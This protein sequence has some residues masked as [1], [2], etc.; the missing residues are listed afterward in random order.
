MLGS[1]TYS[2][3]QVE[4]HRIDSKVVN[5]LGWNLQKENCSKSMQNNIKRYN[6]CQQER[7]INQTLDEGQNLNKD[8][9]IPPTNLL[10]VVHQTAQNLHTTHVL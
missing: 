2:F 9:S 7:D 1:Q 4:H 8:G 5:S 3:T 6:V 10:L